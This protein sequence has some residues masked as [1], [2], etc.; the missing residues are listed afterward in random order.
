MRSESPNG[1]SASRA[2]PRPRGHLASVHD[3]LLA[4][5]G[6]G[7]ASALAFVD[8]L[9]KAHKRCP[10][11]ITGRW[12]ALWE[13]VG[14]TPPEAK[15]ARATLA[16]LRELTPVVS[17]VSGQR[18]RVDTSKGGHRSPSNVDIDHPA[19]VS[20]ADTERGHRSPSNADIESGHRLDR[21]GTSS[22]SDEP[23]STGRSTAATSVLAFPR[24]RARVDLDGA[25]WMSNP[26]ALAFVERIE[27]CG[28]LEGGHLLAVS[29]T[30]ADGVDLDATAA[31]FG[32]RLG[33]AT[34]GAWLVPETSP[35]GRRH[36]HGV[37]ITRDPAALLPAWQRCGGGI[38]PAQRIEAIAPGDRPGLHRTVAYALKRRDHEPGEVIATGLLA[39]PWT[40]ALENP[41]AAPADP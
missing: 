22:T 2:R 1:P 3:E 13:G 31:S 21:I 7:K 11:D 20:E 5:S 35:R 16:L 23:P 15:T 12:R 38:P 6:R 18:W 19:D 28:L 36:I 26:L 39:I 41:T 9:A 29:L 34:S 30:V 8:A 32:Q 25:P 33:G 17:K 24:A 14:L 4:S 27:R 10:V 40:F 37:V